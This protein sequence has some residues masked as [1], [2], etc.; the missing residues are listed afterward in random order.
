MR[1]RTAL[2]IAALAGLVLAIGAATGPRVEAQAAQ[3]TRAAQQPVYKSGVELIAVDVAIVDKNG[4]PVTGVRPDQFEVTIDGQPRRVV[5]AEFLEFASR[6][7]A[8]AA[9]PALAPEARPLFSSNLNPAPAAPQGRLIYLAVD[10]ASFKPL[11]AHGAM[12]AARR[13]IDRLQPSDRVGLV[14][15]PAPGPLVQA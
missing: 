3:S 11:G 10:Q 2:P 6:D 12:E 8:G 5:S 9:R 13:F 1:G 4:N 7:K 14:A 15:F